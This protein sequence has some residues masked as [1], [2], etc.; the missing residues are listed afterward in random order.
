MNNWS[1]NTTIL[2]PML[3]KDV[4]GKQQES[5]H[6]REST[7]A[8]MC[9]CV[10]QGEHQ[11][12]TVLCR[13]WALLRRRTMAKPPLL[14]G[15]W[16][17]LC[18]SV[19]ELQMAWVFLLHLPQRPAVILKIQ[20]HCLTF[21]SYLEWCLKTRGLACNRL[22]RMPRNL[23]FSTCKAM[24]WLF[25]P[26]FLQKFCTAQA[27]HRVSFKLDVQSRSRCGGV[28]LLVVSNSEFKSGNLKTKIQPSHCNNRL[29]I[30][31]QG[32]NKALLYC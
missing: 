20:P 32:A 22:T 11:E 17:V 9:S 18:A 14:Q 7:A 28:F 30:K 27:S 23:Y 19:P 5:S 26:F 2:F 1:L 16:T 25:F 3:R 21:Y 13:R 29:Q 10:P 24:V 4:Q 8:G 6:Q 31:L 15:C 12:E